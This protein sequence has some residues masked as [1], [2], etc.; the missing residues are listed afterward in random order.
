M[1]TLNVKGVRLT[2]SF[3]FLFLVGIYS[4]GNDDITLCCLLF[5]LI[6]ELAHVSSM[7]LVG[8]RVSGIDFY[9]GGIRILA[10]D[11]SELSKPCRMLIY[12]S[13]CL[14]NLVLFTAL[15]LLGYDQLAYINLIILLF[16][17]MP[18]SYF[19]GGRAAALLLGE[20]SP[21]AKCLSHIFVL[22]IL[23]GAGAAFISY[24]SLEKPLIPLSTILTGVFI[25]VSELFDN[26]INL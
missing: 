3:G 26:E 16:N 10:E 4:A 20:N 5:S 24:L 8:T 17:I 2:V 1:I 9:G 12:L 14:M 22:I 19:D 23:A 15:Y 25:G 7:L 21:V 6:H 18:V 13:G 11:I